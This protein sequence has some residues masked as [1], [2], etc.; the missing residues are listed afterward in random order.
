MFFSIARGKVAEG[1]D[2]DRHYGRCVLNIGVPFQYTQS[3]VLRTTRI[4][5]SKHNI[6]EGTFLTF[7][8]LRQT[9]Q[10]VGE[11][12]VRRRTTASWSWPTTASAAR[13][14]RSKLPGWVR[15]FSYRRSI[16][17]R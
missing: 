12:S 7:D 10:C 6:Q 5:P 8:A 13:I 15:Q 9:A 11:W 1:I 14:K 2:F 17:S 3:H 4:P 16:R